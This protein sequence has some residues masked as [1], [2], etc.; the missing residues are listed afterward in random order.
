MIYKKET[1]SQELHNVTQMISLNLK[2][3]VNIDHIGLQ[4][5]R[6]GCNLVYFV[7]WEG[8]C[9]P[10]QNKEKRTSLSLC[11]LGQGSSIVENFSLPT[12]DPIFRSDVYW[13]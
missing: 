7:V 12:E 9:G 4:A 10:Y 11:I 6:F 1:S 3:K 5:G 2:G 13:W 8:D